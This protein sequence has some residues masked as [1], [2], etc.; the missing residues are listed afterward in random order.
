MQ[1][2]V[3]YLLFLLF[4][5]SCQPRAN[6]PDSR[7]IVVLTFDDAVKSH[8]TY[9]APLLQEMGFGA[10]FFIS[11]RWMQDT[12]NFM[13]WDQ[14]AELYKMG[15]EIGNHTWSHLDFS[16]P[17]N[18]SR[19]EGD[20]GLIDLP[21]KWQGIP[22]PVS[23]AYT[24]NFFGPKTVEKLQNLGY[25][26]ARR[27]M[28]PEV[29][30]GEMNPGPLY[31]PAVHHPLLIPSAGDA[32]PDWTLE[33][34]K[35]VV[36][37][38]GD[39]K[40]AVLQFH[41]VPDTVHEWVTTDPELFAKCMQYLKQEGFEVNAMKDLEEFIPESLPEDPMMEYIHTSDQEKM[42]NLPP[43]ITATRQSLEYWAQNMFM[44]HG[45][46]IEEAQ[47]VTDL[48]VKE[49]NE[50]KA[51][52]TKVTSGATSKMKDY[53]KILPYPGGRH[54]RIGFLDGALDPQ[55]GTKFS[56]FLPDNPSNYLVVDLPEAIF[57]NLGLTFLAHRHFPTIW[58]HQYTFI[59]NVDWQV[60]DDGSLENTWTLPNNISFGAIAK[61]DKNS[62]DMELW[63]H[64][65]TA[66]RLDSLKTQVCVMLKG[67]KDF[68]DLTNDNKKFSANTAA[69]K[70]K[71]SDHW[72]LTSWER[73]FNPWGNPDVPCLHTDP[74]FEDCAPGD[75]VRL[76]G[77]LWF[78]E[79]DNV[80]QFMK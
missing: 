27:G 72:I 46:S 2:T 8:Y 66:E 61:T 63:L 75:T 53:L 57:S 47:L 36:D 11:Y 76:K 65:G 34:F 49:L 80:E 22:K 5:W 29:E 6:Q 70:S 39:G 10:T 60:N 73:T 13:N 62:V 35:T 19:L 40:I 55:R 20:I 38:A 26:Y 67:T 54:P 28:Q 78:Y 4:C 1:R 31:D 59:D 68:R 12:T 21:M 64:N 41:G 71:D 32:Y 14:V 17:E 33:H 69:V 24:G 79:G 50:L 15:F 9:V 30:Y 37:R 58:D 52:I 43:E 51:S 48:T 23:F 74:Q 45:Y 16:L 3:C 25:K 77:K 56:V 7:K 42:E 44:N 18:V